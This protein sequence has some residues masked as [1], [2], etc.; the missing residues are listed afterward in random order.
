MQHHLSGMRRHE[1]SC[2]GQSIGARDRLL[3]TVAPSSSGVKRSKRARNFTRHL[4]ASGELSCSLS[5]EYQHAFA[6]T[7]FA[8][9]RETYDL[10]PRC[11]FLLSR[12]LVSFWSLVSYKMFQMEISLLIRIATP[13]TGRTAQSCRDLSINTLR[14][15]IFHG[16]EHGRKHVDNSPDRILVKL[17][18]STILQR[19]D[20]RCPLLVR[21][22]GQL[23]SKYST[24][25]PKKTLVSVF[26]KYHHRIYGSAQVQVGATIHL[27]EK[28]AR[29]EFAHLFILHINADSSLIDNVHAGTD[30][31]RLDSATTK[32][33][34][35][36]PLQICL[37]EHRL[38]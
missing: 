20:C 6:K 15:D 21:Q 1:T 35:S 2:L 4:L 36:D 8:T 11:I 22:Q 26:A 30:S 13:D 23:F 34:M 17:E 3:I 12:L 38:T 10:A 33:E 14:R 28:L 32:G 18:Q 5:I 19:N 9:S 25:S 37:R 7:G 27:A 29:A 31:T 24:P 16:L